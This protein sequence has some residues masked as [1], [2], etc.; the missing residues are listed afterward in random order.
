MPIISRV[1]D[2]TGTTLDDDVIRDVIRVHQVPSCDPPE[3]LVYR[4][5]A[6]VADREAAALAS[7]AGVTAVEDISV[8]RGRA[9]DG[10]WAL[11]ERLRARADMLEADALDGGP[12]VVEFNPDGWGRAEATEWRS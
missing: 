10:W 7:T 12:T 9:R 3:W 1:R 6:D 8:D 11:A 5:A 2:L 4:A